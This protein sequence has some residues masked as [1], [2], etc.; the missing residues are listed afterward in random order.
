MSES[1]LCWSVEFPAC[2]Y[3]AFATGCCFKQQLTNRAGA[4]ARDLRGRGNVAPRAAVTAM[5]M[6][7]G[8]LAAAVFQP[9]TKQLQSIGP[10][11]AAQVVDIALGAPRH[12]VYDLLD[13]IVLPES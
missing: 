1:T 5:R 11:A 3:G 12:G 9:E 13:S 4:I 8:Q 7:R 6:L 2:Q 10:E